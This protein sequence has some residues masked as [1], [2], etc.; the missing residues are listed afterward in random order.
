M[1][2]I[3]WN[4]WNQQF[5]CPQ[6]IL[7]YQYDYCFKCHS[8]YAFDLSQLKF[9]RDQFKFKM[10]GT[11]NATVKINLAFMFLC[12]VSDGKLFIIL[13]IFRIFDLIFSTIRDDRCL[14]RWLWQRIQVKKTKNKR[15]NIVTAIIFQ[16]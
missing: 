4:Y 2:W 8:V 3:L 7:L 9:C 10:R 11:F 13:K 5:F 16:L 15:M 12:L 14:Q 6:P 1:R